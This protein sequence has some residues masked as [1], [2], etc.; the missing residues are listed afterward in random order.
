MNNFKLDLAG[1]NQLM[2]SAEMQ[3]ILSQAGGRVASNAGKGY[4][5]QGYVINWIAVENIFPVTK[6]AAYENAEKHTLLKAL[7]ATKI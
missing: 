5:H 1:L 7:G 3:S 2:K 6:E 4:S